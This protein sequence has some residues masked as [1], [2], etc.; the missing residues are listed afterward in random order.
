MGV[1]DIICVFMIFVV[2]ILLEISVFI[3][4]YMFCDE[5]YLYKVFDGKIGQEIGDKIIN[6]KN[7]KLVFFGWMDVG[8]CNLIIK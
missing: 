3:L 8:I 5:D 4:F 7:L 1:I 6:N 2:F